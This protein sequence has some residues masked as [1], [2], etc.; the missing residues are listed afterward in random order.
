MRVPHLIRI[1]DNGIQ[2]MSRLHLYDHDTI[3][4]K[5][6]ALEPSW[7]LNEPYVSCAPTDTYILVKRTSDRFGKHLHIK[8]VPNRS[9]VLV[10]SLN[11]YK[12]T[13]GCVGV[14]E[15]FKYINKDNQ[16]DL[17]DSRNTLDKL[18]D[19]LPDKTKINIYQHGNFQKYY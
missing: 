4:F 8:N 1:R 2:T 6:V 14:G 12:E 15:R 13:E 18:L 11:Y 19:L 16:I 10:H 9:L 3:I 17:H 5:C 7:I